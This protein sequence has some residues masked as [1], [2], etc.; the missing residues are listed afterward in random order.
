MCTV[1]EMEQLIVNAW[2]CTQRCLSPTRFP[3]CTGVGPHQVPWV[4][5]HVEMQQTTHQLVKYWRLLL[6]SRLTNLVWAV[7]AL[8][9]FANQFWVIFK[10]LSWSMIKRGGSSSGG[11]G[12]G[13]IAWLTP[14]SVYEWVH[15]W[16]HEW[17]NVRQYCKVPF[18]PMMGP[19]EKSCERW[20]ACG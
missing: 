5:K 15:E 13:Y 4:I 12:S 3:W 14:P 10:Y 18:L 2:G 9:C 17:V 7:V 8:I 16:V 1:S 11:R 19:E 6:K 20:I